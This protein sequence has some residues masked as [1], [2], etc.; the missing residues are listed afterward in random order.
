M[1]GQRRGG[2]FKEG[3]H[4]AQPKKGTEWGLS[5]VGAKRDGEREGPD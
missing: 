2:P 4:H 5:N 1:M 3:L